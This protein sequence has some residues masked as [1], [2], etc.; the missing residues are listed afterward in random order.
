MRKII[1]ILLLLTSFAASAQYNFPSLDSLRRYNNRFIT[2]SAINAF[3]D[4]RLNTLLNGMIAWIDSAG[5]GSGAGIDSLWALNDSTIRYRKGLSLLN[6]TIKGGRDV[7]TIYRK[8]GQ[9]SLFFKINGVERAVKDTVGVPFVLYNA[10]GGSGD[11]LVNADK[12]VKWLNPGYG[13]IHSI[14]GSTLT[15]RVDTGATGLATQYDLT[16]ISGGSTNLDTVRT[17]STV[18]ITNSTGTDAILPGADTIRAGVLTAT[19]QYIGHIKRFTHPTTTFNGY[20]PRLNSQWLPTTKEP[21]SIYVAGQYIGF[22]FPDQFASGVRVIVYVSASN[23]V[24]G[25]SVVVVGKSYDQGRTF[26]KDTVLNGLPDTLITL[27][28]GGIDHANRLHIFYKRFRFSSPTFF[29]VDQKIIYSDDEGETFSSPVTIGNAG[30][31]EYLGYGGLVKCAN[32]VSMLSW[33]GQTG[34]TFNV[35]AIKSSDGVTWGSP[36]TVFS[37]TASQ[38]TETSFEHLGGGTIIGLM[39]SEVNDTLYGQVISYDNGDTWAYQGQVSFGQQGTPAWL[40]TFQSQNGK[41]AIAAYYRVGSELRAIYGWADSVIK[42]P[43]YWDA[44]TET[45][46]ATGVLGSGYIAVCHPYQSMYGWGYFYDETITQD[47]ATL[48][49]AQKLPVGDGFPIGASNGISGLTAGRI[50]VAAS[51]SSLT[52][53]S[54]LR[55]DPTSKSLVMNGVTGS[56]WSG[57]DGGVIDGGKSSLLVSNQGNINLMNNLFLGGSPADYRYVVNGPASMVDLINGQL[58][59]YRAASGNAGDIASLNQTLRIGMDGDYYING[60]AG[61]DGQVLRSN[62]PGVATSWYSFVSSPWVENGG[63]NG[64]N[65]GGTENVGIHTSTPLAPLH[66]NAATTSSKYTQIISDNNSLLGSS[67]AL[68][69]TGGSTNQKTRVQWVDGN[70]H[71]WGTGPDN[72]ST[73]GATLQM[74]LSPTGELHL[75]NDA[76]AGN[77]TIQNY[78]GLYQGSKSRFTDTAQLDTR[79]SYNSNIHSTFTQY[80]LVDKAW[81]DSML[82]TLG[83]DG[84][85]LYGGN[86]G[87]GGD[88]SLPGATT[89]TGAGNTLTMTGSQSSSS[90]FNVTNT[91]N[92]GGGAFSAD[93]TG[94]ALTGANSSS[95]NGILASSSS[96]NGIRA[97]SVSGSAGLFKITPSST[98]TVIHVL[99]T[100]RGSSGTPAAGLGGGID[101]QLTDAGGNDATAVSMA[102]VFTTATAGATT[103]DLQINTVNAGSSTLKFT[104][105]GSGQIFNHSYGVGTFTGTLAYFGGWTSSG[106]VIE[107]TPTQ[108]GQAVA[109]YTDEVIITADPTDFAISA[110]ITYCILP[111]LTG[112]ASSNLTL[113]ASPRTG[114]KLIIANQNSHATNKWFFDPDP[115]DATGTSVTDVAND[116]IYHLVYTGSVWVITA[117][118]P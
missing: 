49:F 4:Y 96:G 99:K 63:G 105:K 88:G 59:Y 79:F 69:Y 115:Q 102:P 8:V 1:F 67:L 36:I 18:T 75:A 83:A 46:I 56:S 109:P 107:K 76:D 112:A 81:V 14:T 44:N 47:D 110:G 39:R 2:N 65:Y 91:G 100:I 19:E 7:D 98:N 95:G 13:I 23:H 114:Q 10:L 116:K 12:E 3:T 40:K 72:L 118:T 89:I 34:T 77:F 30:N 62:G 108:V 33:Y 42:G 97:T 25:N 24:G 17:G 28:G 71:N 74:N 90:A 31:D 64:I 73:G 103:A 5:G 117:Q 85:G 80:T 84:N 70:G 29:P 26:T 101:M 52:D 111:D 37:N 20:A 11:T 87:A 61:T 94:T 22:G 38:R 35:Y 104:L 58:F 66:I 106:G 45:V 68:H 21:D 78:G 48:K 53:Y 92:G 82:A 43:S 9:D 6:V 93:G 32:N 50:P 41:M 55:Y 86:G 27:G 16:Q 51:S 54:T 57:H 15:H 60:S 113:P